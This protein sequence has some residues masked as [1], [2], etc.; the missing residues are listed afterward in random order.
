VPMQWKMAA[1]SGG[2]ALGRTGFSEVR[3]I[4]G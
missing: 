2:L 3:G 4:D 1:L